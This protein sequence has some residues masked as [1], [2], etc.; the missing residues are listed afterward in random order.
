MVLNQSTP[1]IYISHYEVARPFGDWLS[2]DYCLPVGKSGV[3]SILGWCGVHP[4]GGL[5]ADS[6]STIGQR[7]AAPGWLRYTALGIK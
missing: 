5:L 4:R 7:K 3:D 2:P 1:H 6:T